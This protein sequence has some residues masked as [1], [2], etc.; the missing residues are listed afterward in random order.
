MKLDFGNMML[1]TE[2]EIKLDDLHS[3]ILALQE[4]NLTLA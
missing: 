1:L 4:E 2:E 3:V